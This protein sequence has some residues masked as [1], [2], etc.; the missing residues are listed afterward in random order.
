MTA[1]EKH[2][3]DGGLNANVLLVF[4]YSFKYFLSLDNGS[5]GFIGNYAL[6][7][8][9]RFSIN[10]WHKREVRSF[11]LL[12]FSQ[13]TNK[14]FWRSELLP[15]LLLPPAITF[16]PRT[17]HP[18]LSPSL[19]PLLL[20]TSLSPFPLLPDISLPSCFR[21]H[22]HLSPNFVFLLS[23]HY[24]PL[25]LQLFFLPFTLPA[26]CSDPL[27]HQ[28]SLVF[29]HSKR[30]WWT[31]LCVP[32]A[33]FPPLPLPSSRPTYST[34]AHQCMRAGSHNSAQSCCQHAPL[35]VHGSAAAQQQGECQAAEGRTEGRQRE[36]AHNLTFCRDRP[37]G[38]KKTDG[39]LEIYLQIFLLFLMQWFC[40]I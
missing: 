17:L 37:K 27:P 33:P 2:R 1:G 7:Y 6:K 4:T 18:Y 12:F 20:V 22:P 40:L 34:G 23:L 36:G 19:Q 35:T 39:Y 15:S 28:P 14:L 25:L 24:Y 26:A 5:C 31:S 32:S 10:M 9:Y 21:L 29:W 30:R 16:P 38:R 13:Q 8:F 3:L 11:Q